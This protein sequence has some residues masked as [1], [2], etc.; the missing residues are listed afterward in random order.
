MKLRPRPAKPCSKEK[1]LPTLD[2]LKK[3][4]DLPLMLSMQENPTVVAQVIA[5]DMVR[6]TPSWPPESLGAVTQIGEAM[7]RLMAC[8]APVSVVQEFVLGVD[9]EEEESD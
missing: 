7:S 2:E 1:N 5:Y 3:Q 8:I 6:Q 4:A 9:D